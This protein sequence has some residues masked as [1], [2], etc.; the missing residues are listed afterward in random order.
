MLDQATVTFW[1]NTRV[2]DD[3]T[4]CVVDL[5]NN[6][7]SVG[8]GATYISS[9]QGVTFGLVPVTGSRF[10]NRTVFAGGIFTS[11][12]TG[13]DKIIVAGGREA[14][15]ASNSFYGGLDLND[16]WMSTTGGAT[17]TQVTSAAPWTLRDGASWTASSQGTMVIFGGACDGGY[18]GYYG[19]LWA[20]FN[21]GQ[22]SNRRTAH[23]THTH[24]HT[25]THPTRLSHTDM[26]TLTLTLTR[27]SRVCCVACLSCVRRHVAAGVPHDVNRQLHVHHHGL[28]LELLPVP[29]WR[30]E[31]GGH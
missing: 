22:H 3:F 9:N 19:D 28:R 23:T 11:A 5:N 13:T 31:P 4:M 14:P 21:D 10:S 30:S 6:V 8:S 25:L 12:I 24:T 29:V 15:A 26:R 7:Y 18:C 16:V 20:S 1:Y 27:P 2:D 17:W